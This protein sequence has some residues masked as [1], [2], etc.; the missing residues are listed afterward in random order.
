MAE[1]YTARGGTIR[2]MAPEQFVTGQSSVQ[3][4]IW[5]LGVMLYELTSG[6]HP[7][8]RPDAED[9][10]VI[11]AIQ[12]S[13][14]RISIRSSPAVSVELKSV[15]AMC[16]KRI[17]PCA[18]PRRGEVREALKT[19]MKAMQLE[20]GGIPGDAAANLVTTGPSR[21]AHDQ[22]SL[23]AGRALSRVDG[24][25]RRAEFGRGAAL[26]QPRHDG[27]CSALRLRPGRRH[28]RPPGAHSLDRRAPF[29]LADDPAHS[30]RWTRSISAS[31]CWSRMCWPATS[32][33]PKKA[34]TST[35]NSSMCGAERSLRRDDQRGLVR[36]DRRAERNFERSLLPCCRASAASITGICS[37]KA[38]AMQRQRARDGSLPD[39]VSEEYLQARALLSSF[40]TRTGSRADLD[41]ARA[42]F[43]N[44]TTGD[45]EFAAGWSGLGIAELQ[46][47]RHGFGGQIHVMTAR[48][49]FDLAY[50]LDPGS[51]EANL[52]RIY[53]LLSRGE[54]ESARHGIANLLSSRPTTGTST[55][56]PASRCAST[57]CTTRRWPSSASALKLNPA[58]AALLYN[59]RAR[60]YQYQNQLEVAGDELAKG[61][62]LEPRHPLLR[63]SAGYQQMR[64]G[65]LHSA[66]EIL[67]EVI[68]DD[69]SMRIA[70][71]TLALCYVQVGNARRPPR[72]SKTTPWPP[73]K[74]TARWPIASPVLRRRRRLQ[75]S[76]AL[77]A[78]RDLSRQRELSLV[79]EESSLE[80]PA[81]QL[82]LRPDSGRFE[83]GLS[84]RTR[85]YLAAAAGA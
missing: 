9:F 44:V 5:A 10:Q 71:P 41:R 74:P 84:A 58:N 35:G 53:M 66:I 42:L 18:T 6:R 69:D 22:L 65:N 47:V 31:V 13:D 85:N 79:P 28:R 29:Q 4:D 15:I 8:A 78:P 34:S 46:Y 23:H 52:Y 77:A 40:M 51:T 55:W 2:Y 54:K 19:I 45:P 75:R 43:E 64:M 60:V 26:Q 16:W 14:L 25:T 33:A 63:T 68:R 36:S 11:R 50:K 7:F 76:A 1:T 80:Q 62:A 17:P 81:H 30:R 24:E 73:P 20:T 38:R 59:H 57:A 32:C 48:R 83:E 12:F 21:K 56:S 49:A 61:L 82:R 67:E 27:S 37:R 72:C 3:S 70:V 39:L